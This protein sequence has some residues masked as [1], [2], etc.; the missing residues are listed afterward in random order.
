MSS[1][2]PCIRAPQNKV[3]F[4]QIRRQ[5]LLLQ[6]NGDH[7]TCKAVH[8]YKFFH[9]ILSFKKV[10]N[11]RSRDP[12]SIRENYRSIQVCCAAVIAAS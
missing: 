3:L 6:F 2:S 5:K 9:K 4:K 8:I 11:Y 7:L 12:K 1:E 10:E